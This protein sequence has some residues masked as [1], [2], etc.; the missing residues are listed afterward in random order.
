MKILR[1]LHPDSRKSVS[2]DKLSEAF[3]LFSKLET[4]LLSEQ[5][6]PTPPPPPSYAELMAKR[7]KVTAENSARSKAAWVKKAA[8]QPDHDTQRLDEQAHGAP[9]APAPA[10]APSQPFEIPADLSIPAFLRRNA[11]PARDAEEPR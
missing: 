3:Q 6:S 10:S 5:D 9:G 4:L 7:K 8:A 2:D 1:C 11:D